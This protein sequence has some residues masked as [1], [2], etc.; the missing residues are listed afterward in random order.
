[1]V[2]TIMLVQPAGGQDAEAI[3]LPAP[4]RKGTLSVPEAFAVRR[5]VRGFA[6][7]PLSLAQISQLLWGADGTSDPRGLRTSPSAGA[8]YPL[9]LY[10]VVGER[11]A[12]D[13]AAGV[14][15][16]LVAEHALQPVAPGDLRPAVVRACLNQAW[17]AAAPVLVVITGEY[18]RCTGRYGQRGVRY[19][20]MEAGNVSQNLFLA[21]EDLGLGAGIVGAFEDEALARALKLPPGREPLLVMP[22][23]YK[24]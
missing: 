18:R 20:H 7:R 16:Y 3:K 11:G 22:V 12:L 13:L 4:A 24:H 1:M 10:L 19:T 17:M 23:G 6:A 2:L 5:T 21:A 14:Y 8:T 15:H 9:D